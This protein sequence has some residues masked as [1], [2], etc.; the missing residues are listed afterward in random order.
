M[1]TSRA[2]SSIEVPKYPRLANNLPAVV[3]ILALVLDVLLMVKFTDHLVSFCIV[4]NLGLKSMLFIVS[5]LWVEVI[6][7]QR[8]IAVL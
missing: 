1:P 2:I 3:N 4:S 7:N 6:Q 5:L 8:V